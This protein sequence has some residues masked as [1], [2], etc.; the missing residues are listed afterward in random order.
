MFHSALCL[1]PS[2]P[3]DRCTCQLLHSFHF[4][5]HLSS[6]LICQPVRLLVPRLIF[7]VKSFDPPILQQP[8]DC[9]IKRPGTQP[10]SSIAHALDVLHQRIAMAC[11][12]RQADQYQ[13]NRLTQRFVF[14]I[15]DDMSHNAILRPVASTVNSPFQLVNPLVAL[16]CVLIS[17]GALASASGSVR[18]D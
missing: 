8:S 3:R 2:H 13:K 1:A 15:A 4:H 7:L 5:L 6:S 17:S 9:S 14:V 11:L 12:L 18:Y 10:H 16:R